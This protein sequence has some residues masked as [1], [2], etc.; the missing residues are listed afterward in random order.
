MLDRA[1][2][3]WMVNTVQPLCLVEN[4]DFRRL[5]SI[6]DDKYQVMTRSTIWERLSVL[7]DECNK[8]GQTKADC[9]H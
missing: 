2:L 9:S 4:E 6:L 5:I 1:L 3:V 7:E 8:V